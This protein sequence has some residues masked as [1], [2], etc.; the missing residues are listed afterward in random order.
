M[1]G[2]ETRI[3]V[4]VTR[5]SSADEASRMKTTYFSLLLLLFFQPPPPLSLSLS[6]HS[7]TLEMSSSINPKASSAKV[8]FFLAPEL[9]LHNIFT[10]LPFPSIRTLQAINRFL[11]LLVKG[12][13]KHI[14]LGGFL[15]LVWSLAI[16]PLLSYYQLKTFKKVSH[17]AKHLTLSG[18]LS[19]TLH[20]SDVNVSSLDQFYEGIL[21]PIAA[22][23]DASIDPKQPKG[24]NPF[25]SRVSHEASAP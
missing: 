22:S 20:R 6:P 17:L 4:S 8:T 12:E 24:I 9:W 11:Y 21:F 18:T 16:L 19:Q 1:E 5:G 7:R 3:R 23:D 13:M 25:L 15:I 14:L 10:F 2:K